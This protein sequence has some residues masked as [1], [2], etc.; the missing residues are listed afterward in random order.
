MAISHPKDSGGDSDRFLHCEEA[1]EAEFKHL[2]CR[3][4]DAGW[5][6]MEVCTALTSLADHHVLGMLANDAVD[7][8]IAAAD[9]SSIILKG[10]K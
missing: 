1:L 8:Q 10:G 9:R 6:E 3:A 5:D 7:Q 4:L 2:V